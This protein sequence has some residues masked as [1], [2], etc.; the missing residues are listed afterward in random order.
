MLLLRLWDISSP[1]LA[2]R[3]FECV[4]SKELEMTK[5]YDSTPTLQTLQW[6][7]ESFVRLRNDTWV[8]FPK[9]LQ[10][11]ISFASSREARFLS[12][13][14]LH[15]VDTMSWLGNAISMVLCK[16]KR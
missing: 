12:L 15:I 14:D 3:L 10:L 9:P 5:L 2:F 7:G 4:T 11:E 1:L 16:E 6:Q 13:F 8:G